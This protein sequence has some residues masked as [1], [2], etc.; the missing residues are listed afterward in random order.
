MTK[1]EAIKILR[2]WGSN[3][4]AI[5]RDCAVKMAIEA[6][7][8]PEPL[9]I[10]LS[11]YS[12]ED[13]ERFRKEWANVPIMA[14]PKRGKWVSADAMFHE[15]PFCC[16]ECGENTWDTVMGKPRYNFCPMCGAKMEGV[17]DE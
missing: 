1:E 6:L 4:P 12:K 8:K 3:T 7:E 5:D 15:A 16:S 14:Q 9:K 13:W 10:D 11:G 17:D 2:H